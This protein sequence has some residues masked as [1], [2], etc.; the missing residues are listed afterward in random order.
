MS[1]A[2]NF[3]ILAISLD[4]LYNYFDNPTKLFFRSVSNWIFKYFSKFVSSLILTILDFIRSFANI[5][6][7]DVRNRIEYSTNYTN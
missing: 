1:D 6:K 3:D 2:K 4:V 5:F 7:D